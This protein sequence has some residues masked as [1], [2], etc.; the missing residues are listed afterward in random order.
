MNQKDKK[1]YINTSK[2]V[3]IIIVIIS[4]IMMLLIGIDYSNI[5][6]FIGI[7]CITIAIP[8][9]LE[10]L[11]EWE[12]SGD[13]FWGLVIL[14]VIALILCVIIPSIWFTESIYIAHRYNSACDTV[15]ECQELLLTL[16]ENGLAQGLEALSLKQS[17][18]E[19]IESKNNI[20]AE[21]NGWLS[22]PMFP[23]GEII[24]ANLD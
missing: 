21:I 4:A 14:F 2:I 23:Y 15:D 16:E 8:Y 22:N 17:L 7:I 5:F 19:A 20:K 10:C 11:L 18:K 3:G 13:R 6:I 12:C 1:L 9:L 24:I